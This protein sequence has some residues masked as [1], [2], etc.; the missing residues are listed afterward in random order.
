[1]AG[2]WFQVRC[3]KGGGLPTR[4]A[5]AARAGQWKSRPGRRPE[6]AANSRVALVRRAN[7]ETDTLAEDVT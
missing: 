7:S 5:R 1:M 4:M 3:I 2:V 6:T